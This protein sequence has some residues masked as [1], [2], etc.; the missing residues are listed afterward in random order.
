MPFRAFG[1]LFNTYEWSPGL[2]LSLSNHL[3]D[4]CI[5]SKSQILFP[6]EAREVMHMREMS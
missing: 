6:T 2:L 4:I 1:F 3:T 5:K